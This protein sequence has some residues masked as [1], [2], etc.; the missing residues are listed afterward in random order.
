MGRRTRFLFFTAPELGLRNEAVAGSQMK[1]FATLLLGAFLGSPATAGADR[2]NN[3]PVAA[4]QALASADSVV[5]YSLEPWTENPE[6]DRNWKGAK[7]HGYNCLGQLRLTGQQAQTAIAEFKKAIPKEEGPMAMCFDPHHALRV[8]SGHH[9]YDFLLCFQCAQMEVYEDNKEIA[10]LSAS[11]SP[12]VLNGIFKKAGIPISFIFSEAYIKQQQAERAKSDADWKRWLAATPESLQPFLTNA[13]SAGISFGNNPEVE[14]G[15]EIPDENKR[16]LALLG[17]YGS[18]AGP[19]SGCPAYEEMPDELLLRFPTSKIISVVQSTS[20]SE[21]Q[22]EGAARFFGG[23]DFSHT[24][25]NDL[26]LLSADLKKELLDQALKSKIEDNIE[27]A[28]KAF[29][30]P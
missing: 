27:R 9:T 11:G 21:A 16:I 7:F 5:L 1:I 13:A 20:M 17:W 14:L 3:L 22:M 28:R 8:V 2:P 24:R 25:P 26:K 15:K 18:G 19:W 4:D 6:A 10:D 30:G 29:G 12:D 23:W